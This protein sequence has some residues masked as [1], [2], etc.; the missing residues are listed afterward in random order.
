MA[1]ARRR[2]LPWSG[3]SPRETV[4][5]AGA[6]VGVLYAVLTPVHL[7]L[8]TGTP[9][10]VMP[11]VAAASAVTAAA[12]ATAAHRRLVP[13]ERLPYVL[14]TVASLPLVNALTHTA[15]AHQIEQTAVTMLSIVA[16][17]AVAH[18]R[19]TVPVVAAAL[20]T[21]TAIVLLEHLGPPS[22]VGH[23]ATGLALAVLLSWAVHEILARTQRRLR[24]VRD[25]L[26]AVAAVARCGRAGEDPRPVVLS[27]VR[28]LA[29]ATSA[30]WV[31]PEGRELV[32]VLSEG[33]DAGHSR[34]SMDAPSATA[35]SWE[36]GTRVFVSDATTGAQA[37]PGREALTGSRSTLCEPVL[38]DG[39]VLAVFVVGWSEHLPRLDDHA[40]SVVSTLA[41]E[42]GA[43]LA[44]TRLRAQ[45]E[46]LATT[47]PMTG[48]ANRRGWQQR[49][50]DLASLSARSG[51][52]LTL[53]LADLDHF[54]RYNDAHGHDAGD[55]LLQ[56]F[57]RTA[58]TLLRDVDVI[59]RWGGEE[60]A[61]AL[62]GS[63][64]AAATVALDRLRQA[65][66]E[67]QTCSFGI[68]AWN[69]TE[70]V[71]ACLARADAALYR[72]KAAGRD[73]VAL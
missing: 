12:L 46:S 59:A 5:F 20:V 72:A 55:A 70:T 19:L 18:A 43:A 47:D 39:E 56:K 33:V 10:R 16:I 35:A 28:R 38:H 52:P 21:W 61:I 32:A 42:A 22:L 17:A 9:R 6:A 23:Y 50:S 51:Q 29:Q 53:A 8:L 66:P 57:S 60:F 1:I 58:T 11:A 30:A 31:E 40:V 37:G 54:K 2:R 64:E 34:V 26:D 48:L 62:P 69:G 65:V 67:G 49:V 36:S 44:A 25:D 45:L 3:D 68:A 63:D 14:A 7:M 73:R 24:N 27:A 13:D 15:V 4:V 71:T 41:A